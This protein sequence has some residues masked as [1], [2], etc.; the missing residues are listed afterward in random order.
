MSI[1]EF[2]DLLE[3]GNWQLADGRYLQDD[4]DRCP[5]WHVYDN[6]G[7]ADDESEYP[8]GYCEAGRRCGLS[9]RDSMAIAQAADRIGHPRLRKRMLARVGLEELPPANESE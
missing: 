3:P 4:D 6:H 1:K 7:P 9:K 5:V 8:T 2:L